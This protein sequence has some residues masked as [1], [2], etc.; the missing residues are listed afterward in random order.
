MCGSPGTLEHEVLRPVTWWI[1]LPD[2]WISIWLVWWFKLLRSTPT[3]QYLW[4][5]NDCSVSHYICHRHEQALNSGTP[6]CSD[7]QVAVINDAIPFIVAVVN[8][9][10]FLL[11]DDYSFNVIEWYYF[12]SDHKVWQ[13][14]TRNTMQLKQTKRNIMVTLLCIFIGHS[15]IFDGTI[16]SPDR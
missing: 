14:P 12:T 1:P 3:G 6:I 16:N 7:R 8:E 15:V 4:F 5:R 9:Y 11:N 10:T 2:L 13:N